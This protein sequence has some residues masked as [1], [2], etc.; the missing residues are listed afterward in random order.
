MVGEDGRITEDP[1]ITVAFVRR[2]LDDHGA[3]LE[4]GHRIIA[5]SVLPPVSVAPPVALPPLPVVPPEPANPVT[6]LV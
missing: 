6:L 5:G 2:F 4:P 3:S 1:A